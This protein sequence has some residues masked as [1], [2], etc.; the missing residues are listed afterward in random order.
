MLSLNAK[1]RI[2]AALSI[3][4]IGS[5]LLIAYFESMHP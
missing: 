5:L 2:I 1:R 3:M 4:I